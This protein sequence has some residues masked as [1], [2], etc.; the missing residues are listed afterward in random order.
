MH[1][2]KH[3]HHAVG[4]SRRLLDPQPPQVM[5]PCLFHPTYSSVDTKACREKGTCPRSPRQRGPDPRTRP[6]QP[7]WSSRNPLPAGPLSPSTGPG[8]RETPLILVPKEPTGKPAGRPGYQTGSAPCPQGTM[9]ANS[10]GGSQRRLRERHYLSCSLEAGTP[11]GVLGGQRPGAAKALRW[12]LS[13]GGMSKASGDQKSG[14][15]SGGGD[16]WVGS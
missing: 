14:W 4:N 13:K 1:A 6:R 11:E 10:E 12:E 9:K 15:P 3:T 2:H 7:A 8:A 16:T 5:D